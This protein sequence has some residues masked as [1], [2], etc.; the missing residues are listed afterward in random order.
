M[1]TIAAL[2]APTGFRRMS[3]Q[4]RP[5]GVPRTDR[6]SA[7]SAEP[8]LAVANPGIEPG[9]THVDEEVRDDDHRREK[10]H[11][12]LDHRVVAQLDSVEQ[13]AAHTG[14]EEN[15]LDDHRASQQHGELLPDH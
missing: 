4:S 13:Q 9:I 14:L 8:E 11:R 5:P 3:A 1:H 7:I 10:E 12:A 15:D 2:A 6:S